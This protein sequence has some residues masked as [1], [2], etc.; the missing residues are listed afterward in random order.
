M[1]GE[2]L[3]GLDISVRDW[4]REK[5]CHL[6]I[7]RNHTGS[8]FRANNEYWKWS[9]TKIIKGALQ[10]GPGYQRARLHVRKRSLSQNRVKSHGYYIEAK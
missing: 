3:V 7:A 2:L 8:I 4:S 10:G 9:C 5:G 1:K 6:R